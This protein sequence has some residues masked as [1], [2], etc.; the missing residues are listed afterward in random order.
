M[1]ND[2]FFRLLRIASGLSESFPDGVSEQE[3][4]RLY[5]IAEEQSLLG[6][7][8]R[9]VEKLPKEKRP[10]IDLLLSWAG[11]AM[12][13][14]EENRL[15]NSECARLT[16]LFAK[17]QRRSAILKGQANARLYPDPLIRQPGDIDIW[18]EG[19]QD[20][21][22]EM[23]RKLEMMDD[24]GD[25]PAE[26]KATL[27]EYHVHLPANEQGVVVEVHF[28]PSSGN[29][30]PWTNRRMMK[31]LE[32]E[33][34]QTTTN[35]PQQFCVPS[36]K[37]ALVMQ[38]SHIQRHF[39]ED[40]IGLRQ[41]CD[42]YW[43]LQHSTPDDR[44]EVA[45]MLRSF[46]LHCTAGALMWILHEIL[47]LDDGLRLCKT[48]RNRGEWMLRDIMEIGRLERQTM[49][50]GKTLICRFMASKWRGVKL[51]RFAFW[52]KI[53][54]DF[55]YS[56]QFFKLIPLRIKYRTFSLAEVEVALNS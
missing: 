7:L 31:W 23:L 1:I 33:I 6:V 15:M 24:V 12:Q 34:V 21:V 47:Y 8:F 36:V 22:I 55:D 49:M 35:T 39:L 3:W 5:E 29:Y 38:L 25:L 16:Q 54:A 17:E 37:F 18:V 2:L 52:E 30:N 11:D 13:L 14:E 9:G 48:D 41:V 4:K 10:D 46:G 51:L 43:L 44:N 50:T 28:L 20:S 32:K 42:Y 19:G 27:T 26:G 45:G 56:I 40:G 53:W